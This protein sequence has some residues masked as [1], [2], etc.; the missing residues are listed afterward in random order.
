MLKMFQKMVNACHAMVFTY[1]LE[2]D[3]TL[4]IFSV[5]TVK[6]LSEFEF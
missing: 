2:V 1:P 6:I 4:Q 5:I 3:I